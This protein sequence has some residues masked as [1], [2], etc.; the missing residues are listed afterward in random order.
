MQHRLLLLAAELL[1]P[2]DDY[3]EGEG[4]ADSGERE[5]GGE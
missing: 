5:L 2:R 3:L 1:E 4:G